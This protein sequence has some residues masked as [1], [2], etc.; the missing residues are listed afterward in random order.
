MFDDTEAVQSIGADSDL[1]VVYAVVAL[2]DDGLADLRLQSER[3]A[4]GSVDVELAER[5]AGTSEDEAE[6]EIF[7]RRLTI[8]GPQSA[9]IGEA[10]TISGTAVESDRVKLYAATDGSYIPLYTDEAELAEPEVAN[11]GTWESEI[12]TNRVINLPGTYRIAAVAD[13]GSAQLGATESIDSDT[14]RMFEVR[15]TTSLQMS[16]GSLTANISRNEIAATGDDVVSISGTAVGQGDNVRVYL[17]GPR[18]RFLGTDGTTGQVES[19]DI[20]GD[21]FTEDY[22][23]FDT[24]GRY[25]FLVISKG[26]DGEYASDYGFGES[27]LQPGL[28]SQQA[29]EI[30]NDEYT[31]AGVDDQIVELTL[32]AESPSLTVDDFTTNGQVVARKVTVSGNSNRERGTDIFIEVLRNDHSVITSSEAKV[33]GSNGM[34]STKIDLSAVETGTYTLHTNS[35]EISTSLEFELVESIDIPTQTPTRKPDDERTTRSTEMPV[36]ES[37]ETTMREPSDTPATSTSM[38][39]FGVTTAFIALCIIVCFA[40]RRR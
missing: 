35:G 18:G 28:T 19:I 4:T 26:R 3:I 13:P 6:L 38:V 11:D 29:V 33:D 25:T 15:S 20:D 32:H 22:G 14:F 30:I 12:E 40:A 39:G 9:A 23:A 34:W 37:T 16:T 17:V 36:E 7:E 2:D 10:L 27:A 24:R 8:R 31:G 21:R 5:L 1:G